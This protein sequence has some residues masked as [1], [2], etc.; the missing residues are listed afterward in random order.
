M[1]ALVLEPEE[2]YRFASEQRVA[3]PP[4][5]S[6]EMVPYDTASG[7]LR[8]HYAGFF[9]SGF[10]WADPRGAKVVLEVRSHDVPFQITHGQRFFRLNFQR[11]SEIPE[12]LY[13]GQGSHYQSQGLSLSKH[14]RL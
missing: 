5:L 11:N 10:G 13:G 1:R 12:A 4:E 7:E 9:D 6:A 3:V 8:T 14:F 2:F